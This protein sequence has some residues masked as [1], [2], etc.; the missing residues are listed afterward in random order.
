MADPM[1]TEPS[2][3]VLLNT[4]QQVTYAPLALRSLLDQDCEPIEIIASDDASTD[5]TYEALLATAAGYDGPHR[6]SVRRN[7]A[8]LGT[9]HLAALLPLVRTPLVVRAHG[10]DLSYPHRVGRLLAEWRRTK[11]PVIGSN[12]DQI[13]ADGRPMERYRKGPVGPIDA[14]TLLTHGF[15]PEFLGATLAFERR[16]LEAPFA[17][18]DQNQLYG[19]LDVILPIRGALVGVNVYIDEPLIQYRRHAAQLSWQIT[20]ATKDKVVFQEGLRAHAIPLRLQALRDVNAAR[21]ARPGRRELDE[22]NQIAVESLFAEIHQWST[23]RVQLLQ[24]GLRASWI[25]REESLNRSIA[26]HARRAS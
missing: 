12:A 26:R 2:A 1:L 25:T 18:P 17:V 11:A 16:L 15:R 23:L 22:L 3:T 5:G 6:V 21:E 20:D 8:N 10:D 7:E 9:R 24:R 13:D 4:Y 19:G 14:K